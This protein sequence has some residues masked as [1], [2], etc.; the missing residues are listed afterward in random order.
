MEPTINRK[1]LSMRLGFVTFFMY[2]LNT[3]AVKFYWYSSIWWFDMFMHFLGGV[4]VGLILLWVFPSKSLNK[5]YFMKII[6]GILAV[7]LAWEVFEYIFYN[8]IAQN[9]FDLKDTISDI[10]FDMMGGVVSV[11]YFSKTIIHIKEIEYN[12]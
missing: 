12:K 11:F 6:L 4:W 7:G 10:F 8:T 3:I 2:F 5:N 1:K 9:P